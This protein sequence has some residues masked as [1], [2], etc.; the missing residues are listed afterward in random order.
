MDPRAGMGGSERKKN[1][2]VLSGIKPPLLGCPTRALAE[3][4]LMLQYVP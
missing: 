1:L 4:D 3:Y 2:F